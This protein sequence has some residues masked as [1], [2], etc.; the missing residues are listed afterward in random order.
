MVSLARVRK[1][2]E[3]EA[4]T[5]TVVYF[6]EIINLDE[7]NA[8]HTNRCNCTYSDEFKEGSYT[9]HNNAVFELNHHT[10][11]G[12]SLQLV[13]IIGGS[14]IITLVLSVVALII[15]LAVVCCQ[16]RKLKEI[17]RKLQPEGMK[18]SPPVRQQSEKLRLYMQLQLK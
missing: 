3:M 9:T 14:L 2:I 1:L 16:K 11:T 6:L 7:D 12:D 18:I 5:S 17:C 8:T 15:A 10:P 13:I 4:I